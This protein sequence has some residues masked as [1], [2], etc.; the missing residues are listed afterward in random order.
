MLVMYKSFV[1]SH[2]EFSC[3]L[4]NP[5]LIQDISQIESI[6]R[7]F[8]SKIHG[9]QHFNYWERLSKLNLQ[10]LQ[11]RR[12]R[13]ILIYM[14]KLLQGKVPNDIG[15]TF[16]FN[17]RRGFT[18]VLKPMV[19]PQSKAQTV[20]DNFFTITGAKLWNILPFQINT[21]TSS[22]NTFKKLVNF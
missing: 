21:C 20:Y 3:P 19:H 9:Y 17:A 10:S 14:W 8:T 13:Y 4:W 22:L 12:E 16:D 15:M 7:T 11:R 1:R 18:A 6:Q 2:L 5:Y